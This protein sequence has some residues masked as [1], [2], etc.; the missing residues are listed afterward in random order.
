MNTF[1]EQIRRCTSAHTTYYVHDVSSK[2]IGEGDDDI[3]FDCIASSV[4]NSGK[5]RFHD[6]QWEKTRCISYNQY[7]F[8]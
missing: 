3:F 2:L 8:M 4:Y 5:F 1:Y 7:W 6:F